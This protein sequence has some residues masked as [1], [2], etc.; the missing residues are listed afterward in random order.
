MGPACKIFIN[1]HASKRLLATS[2]YAAEPL[3]V[4]ENQLSPRL[5]G[6]ARDSAIDIKSAC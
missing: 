1:W 6:I 3:I 2:L 5:S 4:G